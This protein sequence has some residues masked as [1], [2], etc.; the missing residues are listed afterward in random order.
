MSIYKYKNLS[1]S[2]ITVGSNIITSNEM[3][4]VNSNTYIK[5]E[6]HDISEFTDFSAVSNHVNTGELLIYKD[7]SPLS[8][9]ETL[10]LLKLMYNDV[11]SG[12]LSTEL[13]TYAISATS[14]SFTPPSVKWVVIHDLDIHR[15]TV[16]ITDLT[17][18]V[19]DAEVIY[20][21]DTEIH[22]NFNQAMDGNIY[23][24]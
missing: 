19:F 15:P 20:I 6:I 13:M 14:F 17:G 18:Q 4:V 5:G 8:I 2:D 16:T 22:I 1:D 21:S 3:V 7:E 10:R 12:K 11:H 9:N 24:S 23:L